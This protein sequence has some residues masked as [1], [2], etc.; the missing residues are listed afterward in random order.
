MAEPFEL[1]ERPLPGHVVESAG[2]RHAEHRL[3]HAVLR[4]ERRVR[5]SALVADP[6]IVDLRVVPAVDAAH[7]ALADGRADVAP[8]RAEPADGRHR[9]DLPRPALEAV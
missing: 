2:A 6:A 9:L 3:R 5:E 1:G 8:D 7:L 4:V